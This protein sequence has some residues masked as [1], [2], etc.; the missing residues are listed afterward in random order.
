M[1]TLC[2]VTLYALIVPN[3]R[4]ASALFVSWTIFYVSELLLAIFPERGTIEKQLHSLFA[5][6][7]GAALLVS[8]FI[9]ILALDGGYKF[10]EIG[11][12]LVMLS[13]AAFI[14]WIEAAL[15]FYELG[16][17]YSSHVSL[18]VAAVAVK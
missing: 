16:F 6:T 8:A 2:S 5:C 18:L 7:M 10:I 15:F 13:L 9:F 14:S 4:Y 12:I 11:I 1:P 17:I 3:V